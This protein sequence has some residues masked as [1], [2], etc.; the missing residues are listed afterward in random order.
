MSLGAVLILAAGMGTRMCSH[1]PK[2]LHPLAGIPL[3][4]HVLDCARRLNPQRIVVVIG[5]QADKVREA[6]ASFDAG[7]NSELIW[8]IQEEQLGTGHAVR[9][10][11]A[12]LPDL[13]HMQDEIL[14]LNGDTPLLPVEMLQTLLTDHQQAGRRLTLV[15]TTIDPPTGYGRIVRDQD[16][17]L[18]AIVE[19]KDAT[20]EQRRLNEVNA[21]VYCLQARDLPG[22]LARLDRDNASGEFYLTAILPMAIAEEDPGNSRVVAWHYPDAIALAGI[23][24]RVQLAELEAEFRNRLVRRLMLDGV[25]FTDPTSCWLAADVQIG[26][27]TVI[28]PN[29]ILGTGVTIGENCRIGPFCQISRSRIGAGSEILG[30]C[31]LDGVVVVGPNSIGPFAR[32]RPE[33]LLEAHAKVGNFCEIKKSHIGEGSKINHLS[34]VG[35]A[36]IGKKVNVGAGTITCNYD[37]QEKHLTII[38]DGVFIGSDTQLVAPVRIGDGAYI[39]AGATITKEVPSGS[40]AVSRTPQQNYPNWLPRPR[41]KPSD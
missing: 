2:V 29:V 10:A 36:Q 23:N 30:F 21:G 3:L 27:D 1:T 40:L 39:G 4:G 41:R 31:H 6:M 26:R 16:G 25:T 7:P 22:W 8:A 28:Q 14:I 17:H 24:T 15:A 38:G 37:G 32:L 12:H 9:T 33:T 34:Y 18:L 19:E 20:P 35:D 13:P 11:L 5:H